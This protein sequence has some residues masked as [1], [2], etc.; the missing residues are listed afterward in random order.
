[1]GAGKA[2]IFLLA[3]VLSCIVMTVHQHFTLSAATPNAAAGAP[4]EQLTEVLHEGRSPLQTSEK[5]LRALGEGAGYRALSG[6]DAD[7]K[8]KCS[9]EPMYK[10]VDAVAAAHAALLASR[11]PKALV[12][13][14]AGFI[15]SHVAEFGAARMK[16]RIVGVDDLSGGRM[17]NVRP[18]EELGGVF[19]R[20]DVSNDT[21][22]RNLFGSYGP[23][24]YVFHLAAYAAEGLSHHIRGYNY[25][26]NL[27][28]STY[29]VNAAIRQ[30]PRMVRRFVFTSSIASFGAVEDPSELPMTEHTPQRPEDPYGIAK[31]SVELDLKAAAHMF[32]LEYTIFRPHNVY[33]PR[34]NI[35][36][37]FRNAVGIFMNQILHSE[38]MTIFGSGG[39]KRALSYIDDVAHPIAASILF[40]SAINTAFF[41]GSDTPHNISYLA[42]RVAEV[43]KRPNHPIVHLDARKEVE[44]A[45]ASH[46]KLRC[47][48]NPPPAVDLRAGLKRTAAYV[49]KHRGFRPAGYTKIEVY[50]N[51]PPSWRDW[52][53]SSASVNGDLSS[54]N[55]GNDEYAAAAEAAS[56]MVTAQRAEEPKRLL[57]AHEFK[58]RG[59]KPLATT[60]NS[61]MSGCQMC[62]QAECDVDHTG[63]MVPRFWEPP[64]GVLLSDMQKSRGGHPTI[65]VTI[66]AH[67][68]FQC[69]ETIAQ[70]LQRATFPSRVLIAAT[71]ENMPGDP[72]RCVPADL[73]PVGSGACSTDPICKH[74]AQLRV[75]TLDARTSTGP[76]YARHVLSRMYR[77]EAFILQ[78]DAHTH[79]ARGWDEEL[80]RQWRA[81]NNEMAVISAYPTDSNG[82]LTHEG[83][84]LRQTRPIMC[85]SKFA[86]GNGPSQHLMVHG[87]QPEERPSLAG[88]P[89][90]EPFWAAGFSFSRGHW[91]VR[92]PYD[93]YL[94]YIFQGEEISMGM[95]AWTHGYDF[96]APAVPT[97]IYHEY[98]I[99]SP[100]RAARAKALPTFFGTPGT[101]RNATQ[102][103]MAAYRL[104]AIIKL[105]SKPVHAWTQTEAA[106]YGLGTVR[107]PEVFY[108]I[109]WINTQGL[110]TIPLCNFVG[111]GQMHN[112]F[113]KALTPGSGFGID[114]SQLEDFSIAGFRGVPNDNDFPDE[115]EGRTHDRTWS[116]KTAKRMDPMLIRMRFGNWSDA[117]APLGVLPA[118]VCKLQRQMPLC[119]AP[120]DVQ[121][122][123]DPGACCNS[124]EWASSQPHFETTKEALDSLD[125]QVLDQIALAPP[126]PHVPEHTA[127]DGTPRVLCIS[128]TFGHYHERHG[129]AA[130]AR[131]WMARCDGAVILSDVNDDQIPSVRVPHLGKEQ[132]ACLWQ[133]ARSNWQYVLHHYGDEYDWFVYGGDDYYTI[134]DN[135]VAYLGSE[136]IRLLQKQGK[137]LYMG[138]RFQYDGSH[139][140]KS[141]LLFNS[142]GPGYLL[143]RRA[144]QALASL[145]DKPV[146]QPRHRHREEDVLL[147]QCLSTAGIEPYDTRDELGRERF[148]PFSPG[149]HLAYRRIDD[150]DWYLRYSIDLKYGLDCC[151]TN[152]VGFHYIKTPDIYRMQAILY[153]CR[154]M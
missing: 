110:T 101:T 49:L 23:F 153:R 116:W 140:G 47:H 111:S 80:I 100:R 134:V 4:A 34:Q 5:T 69:P 108:K 97:V 150:N 99:F 118:D 18:I 92:V 141:G 91:V 53:N 75:V 72:F 15:G 14:A 8:I 65:L 38:P 24:D 82:S 73:P 12:T 39:Q 10:R 44:E 131:T 13:G 143:N 66:A 30:Q 68:D 94:P 93:P 125:A 139:H 121:C 1:M 70:A 52:L 106:R 90:L 50:M 135:L 42:A 58:S 115:G 19:V 78:I 81:T 123:S 26:N 48:L 54:S 138:R 60:F 6:D 83:K 128:Y 56:G 45:Y 102:E 136:E 84:P 17:L 148:L 112:E 31:H 98:A 144:L 86:G 2:K 29:L 28:A 89:M 40:P 11:R 27:L 127:A 104:A 57:T 87:S 74:Q 132:D 21:F 79:F 61:N 9:A 152:S 59:L 63:R 142:G 114:Y 122:N 33:G 137:P 62:A 77:G 3:L 51:L 22:V 119:S 76:T 149:Q 64:A 36:D 124:K 20:G 88:T 129:A 107:K 85:Q 55:G 16:L 103:A 109:F 95:R 133:K 71:E 7:A 147:S 120:K 130:M 43:M 67:R 32:G 96:Y 25:V 126:Q 113:V 145:I 105:D 117:N 151:S 37:K 46:E 154:E 35:A 41:V 146:C